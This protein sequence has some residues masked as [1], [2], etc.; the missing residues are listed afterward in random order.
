[1]SVTTRNINAR[2]LVLKL[3]YLKDESKDLNTTVL[4]TK[5]GG[6]MAKM[7]TSIKVDDELWREAKIYC[8][9][10]GITLGELLEQLL[11]EKLSETVKTGVTA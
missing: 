8:I 10:K 5:L 2:A 7:V 1:M 6:S 3:Y 4:T 9:Q 11:R